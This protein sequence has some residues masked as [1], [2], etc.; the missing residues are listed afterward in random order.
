MAV[1]NTGQEIIVRG[2][3]GKRE[4]RAQNVPL[5]QRS[6]KAGLFNGRLHINLRSLPIL[7]SKMEKSN[8][9]NYPSTV[10]RKIKCT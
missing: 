9:G 1:T 4:F 8:E 6:L 3:K 2:L 7:R 5:F 10:K